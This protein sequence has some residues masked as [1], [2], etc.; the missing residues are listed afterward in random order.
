MINYN[1]LED[2]LYNFTNQITG[3]QVVVFEQQNAPRP[4]KPYLGL[5][6]LNISKIGTDWQA[7][8]DSNGD[9][10]HLGDREMELQI[11][12]Y[13]P[14]GLDKLEDIRTR[15]KEF[16]FRKLLYDNNVVFVNSSFIMNTTEL[17]QSEYEPRHS[18]DI[19][20]RFTNQRV[21]PIDKF[22]KGL[23]ETIELEGNYE[24]TSGSIQKSQQ[25]QFSKS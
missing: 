21:N 7:P 2:F 9:S 23:I 25:Y 20:L 10:Y 1:S 15:Y 12:Y 6:I 22:N 4:P 14:G 11:N 5:Q 13:G 19:T 3:G 18:M 8:V 17:L 24:D 16:E